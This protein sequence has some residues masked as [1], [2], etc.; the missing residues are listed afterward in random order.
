MDSH[1]W[2]Q[3]ILQVILI[4]LNAIFAC[5]EIAVITMDDAELEMLT[6]EGNKRAKRLSKLTSQPAR[7][8]ATI[9]VAITLSGFLGS[10]FAADNF[11]E[12]IVNALAGKTPLS[13]EVIGTLSVVI[14]TIVLSYFTL[15]FGELVPKRVA[16]RKARGVALALSGLISFISVVFAPIVWLLTAS[17]NGVLRLLRIDPNEVGDKVTEERIRM[18]VDVGSESGAIDEQEKEII[19]NIFEF[20][21][22]DAGEISTHRTEAVFLDVQDPPEKWEEIINEE[23]HS[24][25]PVCDGDVDNVIG[26]LNAKIYLRLKDKSRENV[27]KN[28]IRPACFVPETMKADVL[29]G[30]MKKR[31]DHFAIVL[32]EYGGTEGIVTMNDIL[33]Q[34]VGE[35]NNVDDEDDTPEIIQNDDGSFTVDCLAVIDKFSDTFEMEPETDAVT[36]GGWVTEQIG[37]LPEKGDGFEYNNLAVTVTAADNRRVLQIRVDIINKED[38]EEKED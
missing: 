28:A 34:I 16:Q 24:V 1:I 21:D 20:D 9:Q 5:A 13:D 17:T 18:L 6:E 19:Q 10:A 14:I 12:L 4:A 30:L 37:K 22:T 8:F 15:V 31:R 27:R 35:F 11:S 33:E 38:F 26:V 7:F 36:V 23:T 32:D 2:G 29:F 3:L 25:Y